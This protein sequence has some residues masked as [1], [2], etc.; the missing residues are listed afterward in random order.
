MK[1][2]LRCACLTLTLGGVAQAA[3]NLTGEALM[4]Y[5]DG[6]KYVTDM[7]F[8]MHLDFTAGKY[9]IAHIQGIDDSGDYSVR[10]N[11]IIL[12]SSSTDQ[13]GKR[14]STT[15]TVV[16]DS[17]SIAYA[18]EL[19]CGGTNRYFLESSKRPEGSEV[20]IDGV[21]AVVFNKSGAQLTTKVV[22][23]KKPSKKGTPLRCADGSSPLPKGMSFTIYARTKEKVRV[24]KWENYWYYVYN[25]YSPEGS[26][27]PETNRALGCE[28]PPG[29][30]FGEFV[31]F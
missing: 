17:K 25:E 11:K 28:A 15:C 3:G 6:K 19:N 18:E 5:L 1:N 8:Y 30:V 2:L 29:W 13:R 10:G 12:L 22:F 24:D 4:T 16:W 27:D 14:N 20:M 9:Q 23:R 21:P 7:G 26:R 31:Q